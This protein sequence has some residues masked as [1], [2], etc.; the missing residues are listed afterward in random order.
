MRLSLRIELSGPGPKQAPGDEVFSDTGRTA[1]DHTFRTVLQMHSVNHPTLVADAT[2]VW[3]GRS[4]PAAPSAHVPAW[5]PCSPCDA[6][7]VPG[8]R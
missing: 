3:P 7:P 4:P 5:T 2:A 1:P 6:L 8:L